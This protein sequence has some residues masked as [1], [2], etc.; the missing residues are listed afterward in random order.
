MAQHELMTF[1][2]VSPEARLVSEPVTM[3]L[4]PGHNGEIG[5][6]PDHSALLV[7][8]APGVVSLQN[9]QAKTSRDVF[10]AGGF[11][12]ISENACMVLAEE[13]YNMEELTTAGV[14]EEIAA[15]EKTIADHDDPDAVSR[16]EKALA[17]A[18]V[19][20]DALNGVKSFVPEQKLAYPEIED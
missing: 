10:I 13:A 20:L 5:V 6:G 8:L 9:K 15:L 19:K 14:E 11:A 2:L 12:D 4:I 18:K 7:M 16:A 1:E 3:A 17:V